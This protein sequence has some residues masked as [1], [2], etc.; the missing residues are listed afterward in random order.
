VA[1]ALLA[2]LKAGD[3]LLMTDAVYAPTRHFCD[4][5]LARLDIKTTFYDPCMGAKISELI[6][7]ET[8]LVFLES[9][10]SNTMEVQDVPAIAAAI[11]RHGGLAA[12]DN[13]WSGGHYFKPF[14]R[15]CDISIQSATKYVIGHSDAM[16]GSVT[17]SKETWPRFKETY[18]HMGQFAGPDDMY[19]ALRGLRTLDVRLER[20]MKNALDVAR[21]L[22]E[23]P[24]VARVLHPGLSDD[25]GHALWKRD[26]T[27]AS[28]LFSVV[29]ETT[30]RK[31]VAAMLDGLALFGM[32]YSWGGYES[33]VVPFD[34]A[35]MRTATQWASTGI[36]L[37]FHIGLENP[38][39]LKAD[40]AAGFERL[41]AA[42]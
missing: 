23:R 42:V 27:G 28:G 14:A 22:K 4:A 34:P 37:R 25:A 10:G 13:T 5:V 11:H 18:E 8:R 21:W 24:E 16:L 20:H 19:L 15:G 31:A 29:L 33:L 2:F 6:R 36:A 39:D 38:A 41:N 1:T 9:P 17:C 26:Y 32:G 7:P 12:I 3:H 40:L 30:S 35:V